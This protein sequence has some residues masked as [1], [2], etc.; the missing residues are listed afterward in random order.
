MDRWFEPTYND[1]VLDIDI[2]KRS[3]SALQDS[4]RY[5]ILTRQYYDICT[6]V[7]D[8]SYDVQSWIDMTV[9]MTKRYD[10]I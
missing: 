10:A 1:V 2:A 9:I 6:M 8:W 4:R 3:Q 7:S 5:A